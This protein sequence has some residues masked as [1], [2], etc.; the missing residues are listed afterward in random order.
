MDLVTFREDIGL[1]ETNINTEKLIKKLYKLKKKN[2]ES[3]LNSNKNGWQKDLTHIEEFFYLKELI[4][5]K[6]SEYYFKCFSEL[7]DTN[8]VN[9]LKIFVNKMFCNINPPGAFNSLHGHYGAQFSS[10]I[11]LKC[12]K[13]SGNLYLHNSFLSKNLWNLYKKN[14]R[15]NNHELDIEGIMIDPKKNTGVIFNSKILHDV[16]INNSKE[17]RISLAYHIHIDDPS[18]R[19]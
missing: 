12:K 11:W 1:F 4:C 14:I 18:M 2:P 13:N 7:I 10:V 5:E 8:D 6:F 15:L 3:D 9:R 16:G 19:F 17:D